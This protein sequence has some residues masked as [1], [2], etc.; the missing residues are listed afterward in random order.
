ML[1]TK[2]TAVEAKKDG[3][4]VTFEGEQA[5]DKPQRYDQIL[6]AVGRKPNGH[7]IGADKAGVKCR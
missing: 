1:K 6:V 5:P 4:Y 7:T 2:V 3:L